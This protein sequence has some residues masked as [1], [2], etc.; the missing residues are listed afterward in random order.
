VETSPAT[1][2]SI[3]PVQ[4]T[5]TD[6]PAS[7]ATR[8]RASGQR[9]ADTA[10][11]TPPGTPTITLSSVAIPANCSVTASRGPISDATGAPLRHDV[12]RSP[13]AS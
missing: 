3:V 1:R 10:A 6:S 11:T 9:R 5:G 2:I 12:P 4:N 8:T 13:C 7:E